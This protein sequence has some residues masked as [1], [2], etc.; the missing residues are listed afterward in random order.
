MPDTYEP[1]KEAIDHTMAS[2]NCTWEDA[3]TYLLLRYEG[4]SPY[5]AAIM[6]GISDPSE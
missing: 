4:Y 3:Y 1:S 2:Y 6:S 5:Q